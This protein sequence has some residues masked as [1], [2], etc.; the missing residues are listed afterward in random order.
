M[1]PEKE[2]LLDELMLDRTAPIAVTSEDVVALVLCAKGKRS[3]RRAR[4]M[5][6]A[7]CLAFACALTH[8]ILVTRE[9]IVDFQRTPRTASKKMDTRS[10]ISNT[11]TLPIERLDDEGLLDLL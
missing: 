7:L 6:S 8:V 2:A 3:R 10:T 9:N 11:P 1:D 4:W 5:M